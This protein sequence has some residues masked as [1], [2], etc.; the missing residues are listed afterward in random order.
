MTEKTILIDADDVLENLSQ[1]WVRYLNEKFGTHT[2]YDDVREWD[3]SKAFPTLQRERVYEAGYCEELYYRLKPLP[4]AV[5]YVEQLINDGHRV[6]IV[7]NTPYQVVK[8]KMEEVI[9][10]FF[11][12]LTWDDVILTSRK[13]M[14]KGDILVD[15]GVHNLEDGD[16]VKILVSTPYNATYDAEANGMFRVH[17]WTEIYQKICELAQ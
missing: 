16:Y 7:T 3:M 15:D 11:P 14:I 9:F 8:V 17:S 5:E 1:E 12:Y 10:K 4:G 2:T 13:Q 6:Y